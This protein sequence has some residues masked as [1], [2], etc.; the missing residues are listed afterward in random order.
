[1]TALC[2]LSVKYVNRRPAPS[3]IRAFVAQIARNEKKRERE[4]APR[5]YQR[6]HEELKISEEER[7]KGAA[8][9]AQYF[10]DL[11]REQSNG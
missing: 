9:Y 11:K 4:N 10:E 8:I 1:M 7:A 6:P 5:P 3:T 2:D